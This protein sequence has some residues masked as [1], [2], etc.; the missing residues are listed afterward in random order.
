MKT[1]GILGGLGPQATMDFVQRLHQVSR[2]RMP[3]FYGSGYP[4]LVVFYF[5]DI[6]VRLDEK[7][8]LILPIQPNPR[9]LAA[10]SALG[11][12]ADFLVVPS[13]TPHLFQ[14]ELEEASGLRMLS[15]IDATLQEVVRRKWKRVGVLGFGEPRVYIGR[16]QEMDVDCVTIDGQIRD[17][18]DLAIRGVME[19]TVGAPERAAAERAIV[20]LR[21]EGVDGIILGCTEIPLLLADVDGDPGLINPAQLL[22]ETA[23]EMALS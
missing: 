22:A 8:E 5:R 6:P 20:A 23:V 2:P 14:A 16:L 21:E 1:I 13:N 19:G 11:P 9:L 4:P 3:L 10:A 17:E 7:R 12:L 15:I 18:L